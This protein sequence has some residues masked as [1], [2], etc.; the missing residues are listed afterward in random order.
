MVKCLWFSLWRQ[1]QRLVSDSIDFNNDGLFPDTQ[2]RDDFVSVFGGGPCS[3]GEIAM[4]STS[5]MT[6]SSQT[7]EDL[8][9]FVRVQW[10]KCRDA[11]GGWT[12]L[13]GLPAGARVI[14]LS[15]CWQ[16]KQ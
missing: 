10:G 12:E 9:A 4:T 7:R 1:A 3:T 14:Y 5:T 11:E 2:D 16:R 8:A 15:F 6:E 13:Q